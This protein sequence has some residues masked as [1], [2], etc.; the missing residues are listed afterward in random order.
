VTVS[1][2]YG[3]K[4]GDA[5]KNTGLSVKTIRFYCDKGL[6]NP[7]GRTEGKYRL[8]DETSELEL[9]LVRSLRSLDMPVDEVRTFMESRR[10]GECSCERL[11]ARMQEKKGEIASKVQELLL[12]QEA[13]DGM[14]TN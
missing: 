1:S 7:A 6:I 2:M 10:S 11:K 4:I 14:L 5:A 12:L 13:I 3:R 9:K 8:F